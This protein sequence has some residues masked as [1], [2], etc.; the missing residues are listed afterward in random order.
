MP[1]AEGEHLEDVGKGLSGPSC[2]DY[3]AFE[4]VADPAL[5]FPTRRVDCVC[6]LGLLICAWVQP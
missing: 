5:P 3:G 1:G 2:I 4:D 6:L